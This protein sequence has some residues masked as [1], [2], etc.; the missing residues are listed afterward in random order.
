ME[1]RIVTAANRAAEEARL[2]HFKLQI[3]RPAFPDRN[4]REPF[5]VILSRLSQGAQVE[6]CPSSYILF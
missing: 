4:E 6:A 3:Y 2:D 5:D 1:F